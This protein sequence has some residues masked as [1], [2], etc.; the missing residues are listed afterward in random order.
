M[1]EVFYHF[2]Y[3]ATK[4]TLFRKVVKSPLFMLLTAMALPSRTAYHKLVSGYLQ[5]V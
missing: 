2:T 3:L 4:M 1:T 5:M